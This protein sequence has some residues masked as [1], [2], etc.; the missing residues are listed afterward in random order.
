MITHIS[1]N[2]YALINVLN[3]PMAAGFTTFTG[4]TGAG[5]SILLGAI[6]LCLGKRADSHVLHDKTKKCV[7]ELTVDVNSLDLG[8]YFKEK[9]IDQHSETIIRR[10]ISAQGRSRS[11]VNDCPVKLDVLQHIGARLVDVHSQHD[12][13]LIN[14]PA[15]QLKLVDMIAQNQKE[16]DNYAM[17]YADYQEKLNGQRQFLKSDEID[18]DIDYLTFLAEELAAAD[19]KLGEVE[20]LESEIKTFENAEEIGAKLSDISDKLNREN[21]GVLPALGETLQWLN[22]IL[23]FNPKFKDLYNRIESCKIEL[24]DV[25]DEIEMEA[26]GVEDNPLKL[27]ELQERYNVIQHLLQKHRAESLK[28][29]LEKLEEINLKLFDFQNRTL[30]MKKWEEK[31][32]VS[33]RKA[34]RKAEELTKSRGKILPQLGKEINAICKTLNFSDPDFKIELEATSELKPNGNDAIAFLFS[35]NKGHEAKLLEKTASG[36]ELSRV[37]L[38]LKSILAK[39]HGLPTV[40]FDEIDTG[41]SGETAVRVAAILKEMGSEMQVWAITHLPQ[42]AASGEHHYQVLKQNIEGVT[43]TFIKK[44]AQEQRIETVAQMLSG[45]TPTKAAVENAREL[46]SLS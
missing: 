43:Q 22:S 15:Y 37:M 8:N 34:S 28:E 12:T 30:E 29:L 26:S 38:A 21:F 39:T 16:R 24:A 19:V 5:K 4:E 7:V 31:V 14:N 33:M 40:I 6:G 42:I 25:S 11:F 45:A 32:E 27:D 23:G 46:I 35:A 41:V 36:G 17:A 1:I 18:I 3:L 9:E 2:N 10:E 13:L 20:V 44:L